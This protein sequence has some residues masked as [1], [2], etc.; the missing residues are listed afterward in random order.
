MNR[1]RFLTLRRIKAAKTRLRKA[2][3]FHLRL[4]RR[5]LRRRKS[6]AL[7]PAPR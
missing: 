3:S 2:Q 6:C 4:A 1:K 5:R 7:P